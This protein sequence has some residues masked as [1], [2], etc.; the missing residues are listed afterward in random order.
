M[1][2]D[3]LKTPHSNGFFLNNEGRFF[4]CTWLTS[5]TKYV[6]PF[7]G[8]T[9]ILFNTFTFLP[10][11]TLRVFVFYNQLLWSGKRNEKAKGTVFRNVECYCQFFIVGRDFVS[12]GRGYK[13]FSRICYCSS[14]TLPSIAT[15]IGTFIATI[16]CVSIIVLEYKNKTFIHRLYPVDKS[17][18]DTDTITEE[19]VD[20]SNNVHKKTN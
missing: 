16:T 19:H 1:W 8:K 12:I 7:P 14:V 13:S 18:V 17:R 2:T 10:T 3:S 9:F 15:W 5:G 6:F 11:M 4:L 20:F